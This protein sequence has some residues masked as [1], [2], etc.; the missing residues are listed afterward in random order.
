MEYPNLEK[1][2][3]EYGTEIKKR[4]GTNV[5]KA[6]KELSK[7]NNITFQVDFDGIYYSVS[8]NLLFYWYYVEYGRKSGKQPPVKAIYDWI[9]VKPDFQ[10]RENG[11]LPTEE[12]L[13]YIIARSIG[14]KGTKPQMTLTKTNEVLYK[15]MIDDIR[16][17]FIQDVNDDINRLLV[18][19]I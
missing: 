4:Y 1:V 13:A 7:S 8:L 10:K 5:S 3:N 17:A 12:G 11:Y 14:K 2:L 16:E 6:S 19:I 15:E 18:S 9:R